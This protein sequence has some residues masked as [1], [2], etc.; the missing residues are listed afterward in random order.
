M[1]GEIGSL[2]SDRATFLTD[3]FSQLPTQYPQVRAVCWFN[4]WICQDGQNWDWP[5]E[6][7]DAAQFQAGIASSC[8]VGR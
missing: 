7:A 3:M 8:Y 5:L 1:I 2:S 4:W 6:A